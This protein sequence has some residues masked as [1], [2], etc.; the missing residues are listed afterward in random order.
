VSALSAVPPSGD[1]ITDAEYAEHL[2]AAHE[3]EPARTHLLAHVL[4]RGQLADLPQPQPLIED[5]LDQRT[6]ALL[7]GRNSSG[8]SFLA[9]D[10]SCS[11]VT[12]HSWQGRAV[13]NPGP[14]LYIAAEG[15]HGLHQRISAWEYAWKRQA[16]ELDVLPMPV[17]FF[18]GERTAELEDIVRTA[19]Y[20]M[21]VIDTWARST[22]GGQENNNSDSTTAFARVDRIRRLGPTVLVVA[23]TD[24]GDNKARGAT[25]LEDN[26]DTVYRMAGDAIHIKLERTKRKDGPREDNHAL[27]LGRIHLG[28]DPQTGEDITS[29]VI[30]SADRDSGHVTAKGTELLAAFMDNFA[31]IGCTKAELRNVAGQ[32]PA[33]FARSLNALVRAGALVNTASDQR[34][35]YKPGATHATD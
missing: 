10:W 1:G 28:Q 30:Q 6:V 15:A 2:A 19:Q 31:D 5:T 18:T 23:H 8:K 27:S 32:S 22:V 9:L 35:F 16:S 29:C 33:T 17:N 21:V 7:A 20:R 11:V 4:R 34:P 24:A 3:A 14:V 25:A 12:G 26:V 13:L